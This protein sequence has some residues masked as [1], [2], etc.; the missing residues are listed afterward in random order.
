[1][2]WRSILLQGCR[3][4]ALLAASFMLVSYFASSLTMKLEAIFFSELSIEFCWTVQHLIAEDGTV[5]SH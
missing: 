4:I 1:M 2:F 3:V 5:H